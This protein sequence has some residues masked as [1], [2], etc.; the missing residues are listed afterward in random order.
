MELKYR[1]QLRRLKVGYNR[2]ILRSEYNV[3]RKKINDL[4]DGLSNPIHVN[5]NMNG[6][7]G[8][9][10]KKIRAQPR[11]SNKK[12]TPKDR[13]NQSKRGSP[14]PLPQWAERNS[15][16]SRKRRSKDE[17]QGKEGRSTWDLQKTQEPFNL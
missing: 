10:V 1:E 15:T 13:F 6:E 4:E 7:R 17:A 12:G 14:L 2:G 16:N 3:P 8:K 11:S 9:E 5:G